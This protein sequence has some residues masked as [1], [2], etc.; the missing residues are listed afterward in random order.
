MRQWTGCAS[1]I[2]VE[3]WIDRVANTL[4]ETDSVVGGL[5]AGMN[6]V[7]VPVWHYETYNAQGKHFYVN[8]GT[9][10]L[11]KQ[12][13]GQAAVTRTE[14]S[15]TLAPEDPSCPDCA[16]PVILDPQND[17]FKL[18]SAEDGVLF[19]FNGDGVLDRIAWTEPDSDDAWLAMDRN[20]NGIIDSGA[21][22]FGNRTPAYADR[23]EP[24]TP[25]GFSA[26][27]FLQGLDYGR[28][29]DDGVLNRRDEVFHR[30]LLWRD[31]NHDGI[32]QPNEL[33][34]ASS[35]GLVSI[36]V[37]TKESRRRDP[38]GNLFSLR[39]TAEWVVG[40]QAV[41]NYAY[42]VWLRVQR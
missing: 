42:D 8:F 19:D 35:A 7:N 38:N 30:L 34:M 36:G 31:I 2:R 39:A 14:E 27:D 6:W 12:S 15:P 23:L 37:R 18:T 40:N 20:G 32:S 13:H 4:V 9:R 16:D 3:G 29:V 41:T 1:K 17:G 5:Y 28:N 22:L 11:V 24:V 26:L 21:E 33:Q 25:T 10:M